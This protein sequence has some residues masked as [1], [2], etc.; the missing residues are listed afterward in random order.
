[1]LWTYTL[2]VFSGKLNELNGGDDGINLMEKFSGVKAEINLKIVT[3]GAIQ[4]MSWTQYYK[5]IYMPYPSGNPSHVQVSL[6]V[7]NHFMQYHEL[8]FSTQ[9]LVTSHLNSMCC[10]MMVSP[11][12]HLQGNAQYLPIGKIL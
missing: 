5:A 3:Y 6:L 2:K 10:L 8:W 11:R 12:F 1:M 7:T 9:K 4:F